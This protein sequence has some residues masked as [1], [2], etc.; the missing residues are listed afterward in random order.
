[1]TEVEL[2]RAIAYGTIGA[3]AISFLLLLFVAAPYGRNV[4]PGWGP[5]LPARAGWLLME[6]PAPVAF[7]VIFA[8]GPD[9]ARV[10]PLVMLALWQLHYVYRSF[11]FPFRLEIAG[12]RM[13][14]FV[15]GIGFLFNGVNAYLNARWISAFADYR[16]A[17]LWSPAFAGGLLLFFAGYAINH[18]ADGVLIRLRREGERGYAIPEGGLYRFVSCPNYLGELIEWLG[19][20]VLTWSLAGAAFFL[21]TAANLVPRALSHHRFYRERFAEYP[22]ERRAILPFIL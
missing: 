4:R 10:A 21:F 14:L 3:G 2:H 18:H 13:T 22:R 9:R 8:L 6:S 15:A 19:W 12:K 16:I 5:T 17:H 1:M 11:I 20:A 7:A